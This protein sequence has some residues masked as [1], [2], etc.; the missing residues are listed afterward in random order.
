MPCRFATQQRRSASVAEL[1]VSAPPLS[2]PKATRV[3]KSGR[4]A[5]SLGT[6]TRSAAAA[7]L[8]DPQL[9][10]SS[11][12][13]ETPPPAR[14]PP[15]AAERQSAGLLKI[16]LTPTEQAGR[17]FTPTRSVAR[18]PSKDRRTE[19]RD[20]LC[21]VGKRS[22]PGSAPWLLRGIRI[23]VFGEDLAAALRDEQPPRG[24]VLRAPSAAKGPRR[25]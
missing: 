19:G 21:P 14:T 6:M 10:N 8:A 24:R 9:R 2:D 1:T 20:R 11:R 15:S 22:S 4:L 16:G 5:L 18:S 13:T 7:A 25:R 12:S 3:G 23:H 17:A